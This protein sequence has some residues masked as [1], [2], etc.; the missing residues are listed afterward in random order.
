MI[1]T[2]YPVVGKDFI[3][4]REI[5]QNLFIAYR[6]NQ[7]VGM[8][9]PRRIGKTSI[10]KEFLRQLCREKNSV[11][12]I[13]DVQENIGTPS[14]FASRLLIS[15][16]KAFKPIPPFAQ[17]I[18]LQPS[19]LLEM[20]SEIKSR[21]LTELSQTLFS[22]YPPS[23]VNERVV[24]EKIWRFLDE[25]AVE[26]KIKVALVLDEFQAIKALESY[27]EF[28]GKLLGLL[29]GIISSSQQHIW[30]L[31][32]GSMVRL[33]TEILE[34]A[35]SP[36]YGRVKRINVSGFTREDMFA[37][38]ARAGSKP[39]SGEAIQLLWRITN[40]NPY[41]VIAVANYTEFLE[42][43][44]KYF[45][46]T[47]IKKAFVEALSKGELASH[48][49]YTFDTSFQRLKKSVL[50]EIAKILSL[51]PLPPSELAKELGRDI[52]YV[53]LPLRDLQDLDL[54]R[55]K[56]KRYEISDFVLRLWLK[57]VY[58]FSEPWL[59]K[60]E[61]DIEQN[62]QENLARLKKDRGYFFES[63]VRELLRKFDGS[64][65]ERRLLPQFSTV[66]SLNIYDERG[67]VFGHPSNIEIDALCLGSKIWLCE[68][69]YRGK[70]VEKRDISLLAQ[71][72][73]FLQKK[74]KI[75]INNLVFISPA[76]F[77]EA[78]LKER[79]VWCIDQGALNSL[80]KKFKMR[81]LDETA[82]EY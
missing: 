41:Y 62:Y 45:T 68:F 22:Y 59:D 51:N 38:I 12:L 18:D 80:L 23:P 48:C 44:A 29:N 2:S 9:G 14:R 57:N 76:G 81:R 73:L 72:K 74:L 36:F 61:R 20:A 32:T 4:R 37:L 53:N 79:N 5:I 56:G 43:E 55:K 82:E 71:K 52:G 40:G 1:S 25:F 69:R 49:K 54:V 75:K 31:F 77:T 58:S 33:M 63:Y 39:F 26:Q 8:V 64:K 30:Y 16:L 19:H 35:E 6:S 27:K 3:N 78:A 11:Q 66:E 60:I 10:A 34:D 7:N 50:K 28:R 65:F 17:E 70:L 46:K 42:R 67:K 24:F 15:F 21:S 47:H 13:F